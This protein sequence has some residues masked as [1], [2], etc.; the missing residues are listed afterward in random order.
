MCFFAGDSAG[1]QAMGWAVERSPHLHWGQCGG[2]G[3]GLGSGEVTPYAGDSSGRRAHSLGPT[4]HSAEGSLT[5]ASPNLPPRLDCMSPDFPRRGVRSAVHA[6]P[7]PSPTPPG[8][9]C[10]KDV[11]RSSRCC[12]VSASSDVSVKSERREASPWDQ[13]LL[14]WGRGRG[15][16]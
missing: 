6:T 12:C 11:P 3:Y 16:L 5:S 8:F 9:P 13:C 4:G 2:P 14:C 15:R 7:R 10:G 1:G